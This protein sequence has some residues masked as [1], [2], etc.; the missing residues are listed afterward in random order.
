MQV[1]ILVLGAGIAGL[2]YAYEKRNEKTV[3]FEMESF[4]GG[5]CH[6]FNIQGFTFDS[7]VHLS[8]TEDPIA[9]RFFDAIPYIRH[10]PIAFNFYKG[11]WIKHPLINNLYPFEVPDKV[12]YIKSFVER[13]AYKYIRNYGEW[14]LASYG[15]EIAKRF[16]YLYTKKYWTLKPE[17]LTTS[18][19]GNRLNSPDVGKILF[20]AFLSDT[21]S[22]YYAKEMHY[23]AGNGGYE[24]FLKPLIQETPIEYNKKVVKVNLAKKYV[25]C[26]DGTCCTYKK[27]VSS[28]PLPELVK[29]TEQVPSEIRLKS[30]TLKASKISLVSL[31]F[32]KPDISKYLWFYIYDEDIMAARVNCPSIKSKENTPSGCSSMQFEIY[33]HPDSEIDPKEVIENTLQGMRK[34]N[35]CHQNDIVLIDYRLLLYGNV[36][37]LHGMEKSRDDIK[38]Y[39]VRHGVDLIGRFGE[40]DYL[41]SDQSYLSGKKRAQGLF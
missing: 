11:L 39:F 10:E 20:G 5:L 37:F 26:S 29:I 28:I 40:W 8:F 19:I 32:N 17:A 24:T 30:E 18:W 12:A 21:G 16:Y 36:L 23:P 13:K 33:H 6:S 9:R 2:A 35:L 38:Q 4:A 34:V 22:D 15:E 27:L 3:I 41:W 31:G 7:A 25:E 14:L 1:D